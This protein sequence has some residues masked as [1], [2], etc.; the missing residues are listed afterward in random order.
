MKE[1]GEKIAQITAYDF[2]T[3]KNILMKLALTA[4]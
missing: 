3:A 4:Y 2:T 1:A